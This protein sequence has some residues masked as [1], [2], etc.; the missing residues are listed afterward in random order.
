M[1]NDT[2]GQFFDSPTSDN[3]G[4][5]YSQI[6]KALFENQYILTYVSALGVDVTADLT[7]E[8]YVSQTIMGDDT[9]EIIP[10]PY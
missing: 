7:I 1:A 2:G 3:L 8:A 6:A 9:K 10:C 5:I 4:N